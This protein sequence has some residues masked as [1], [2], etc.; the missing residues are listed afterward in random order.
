[1]SIS[2]PVRL[3]TLAEASA[4]LRR[5]TTADD[6]D[7]DDKIMAASQIVLNYIGDGADDF[8]N[9]ANVDSSGDPI[10][11]AAVKAATLMMVGVLYRI[12]DGES[13]IVN[14]MFKEQGMLPLAVVALL[15]PY[16]TPTVV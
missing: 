3:V 6:A 12:R 16:R 14:P 15:Y 7:L 4:H 8:L 5:D 13:G 11:P 9:T 1:M 2:A 10:I